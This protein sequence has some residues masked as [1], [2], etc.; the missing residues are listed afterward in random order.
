MCRRLS[1]LDRTARGPQDLQLIE[2]IQ[3]RLDHVGLPAGKELPAFSSA[4]AS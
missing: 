4:C 2:P 3:H 1:R